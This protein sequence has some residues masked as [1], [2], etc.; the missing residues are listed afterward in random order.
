MTLIIGLRARDGVVVGADRKLLREL[1]VEYSPKYYLYQDRIVLVAVGLTGIVD[2]FYDLL[3]SEIRTRRGIETLYEFKIVAEDILAELTERYGERV[4]EE[5]PASVVLAGLE[6]IVVGK[7]KMYYIY[8]EGYGEASKF[9]CTGHG[10]PYALSLAKF[11]LNPEKDIHENGRRIA[12]IISWVA[13]KVD[14]SVGGTPDILMIRDRKQPPRE[15][16]KI[17]QF[18]GEKEVKEIAEKAENDIKRLP[19]LLGLEKSANIHQ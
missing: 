14:T 2:D 17:V 15:D 11:L 10:A 19:Q 1:E 6:D 18:L 8:G 3:H 12:Y 5:R 4:R 13:E 9:V 7:A 16:E